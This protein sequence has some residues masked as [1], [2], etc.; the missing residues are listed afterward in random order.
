MTGS[1]RDPSGR[2]F[3]FEDRALRLVNKQG[4]AALLDFLATDTAQTLNASG[5][6][7]RT[8]VL[9]A[10]TESVPSLTPE[11][12]SHLQSDQVLLQHDRIPVQS[13]P[14]EWP[15]EMLHAAGALTLDLADAALTEN[16]LLKDATPY[17]VL[18]V[19]WRPVFVDVL[20]FERRDPRDPTWLP[21]N[22]FVQ[23]FLLPLLV[24]K[25]FGLRLDQLLTMDRDGIE[26]AQV[27]RLSGRLQKLSP[28]FLSLVSIPHWLNKKQPLQDDAVYEPKKTSDPDRARFILEQ[29]L[30]RLRRQLVKVAPDASATSDWS[31]YMTPNKYFSLQYLKAKESFVVKTLTEISPRRVLDVGCN[32]GYFSAL[33]ARSG[34]NV[35]AIDQ[36]PEVVGALWRRAA[37]EKSSIL[38]LVVNLARPTPAIGWRNEECPSFLDRARGQFDAVLMLA[39]VHHMLVV[40]QI[41]LPAILEL[42]AELTSQY[43]VIEFVTPDDP[44]F[45]RL[46]RGR[47]HLYEHL[48]KELFESTARRW[49]ELVSR[50]DLLATRS[51]YLLRK[52]DGNN[53][54]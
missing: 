2:L 16:Y 42:A 53:G 22:Q 52:R 21:F 11:I 30:K 29:Q 35:V 46:V 12:E 14:Y 37:A 40:E 54:H 34:A 7:V 24:N 48:T 4:A 17:N 15:A 9:D 19:D 3:L 39:V 1:F 27:A 33:A 18:F 8:R 20:S 13:F 36:D 26:P 49:F 23:T 31:E 50:E 47:D 10:A 28:L 6:L 41:P 5:Q 45:R 38:P 43:L 44:M 32:T 25:H 51:I